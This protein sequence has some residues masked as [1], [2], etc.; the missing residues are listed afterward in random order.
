MELLLGCGHSR[1]KRVYD[2]EDPD[3]HDLVTLDWDPSVDPDVVANLDDYRLPFKDDSF[4]EIHA[5]EV[6]EHQGSQGDWRFFFNQFDEFARI[7]RDRGMLCFTCPAGDSKWLWA[8]P[9]HRRHI[10]PETMIFLDRDQY[11]QLGKT[12]MTDYRAYFKSNWKGLKLFKNDESNCMVM[13]NRKESK[14]E[15]PKEPMIIQRAS[16]QSH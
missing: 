5:Y 14:W 10:S 7:L 1:V 16:G 4:D 12:A 3:W 2:P 6:L 11:R 15:Q 9:G 8:D 13:Q